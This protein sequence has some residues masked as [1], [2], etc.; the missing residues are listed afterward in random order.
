VARIL[1]LRLSAM[2]DVAMAV[3]VVAAL[4]RRYPDLKISLLT[5]PFFQ[6]FFREVPD[7]DFVPF[8]KKGRHR[9]L[10]GLFRLYREIRREHPAD[11]VAD[12]HNVLR[13]KLLRL[14]FRLSGRR[15]AVIDKGRREKQALTRQKN[16]I[17]RPL[18]PTI[19]RYA[20]VFA[21]LGYP[22]DLPEAAQRNPHPVPEA[23]A[24]LS[25][26]KT[27]TWIGI[28]PF[29]Q[30][31]GKR[32]PLE[33]MEQVIAELNG[34][35]NLTLFVFGGGPVEQAVA[36][37]WAEKYPHVISAIG[38]VKLAQELDLISNLDSMVSMD[39]SA[40]HMASLYGVPVISV[41]GAT[42][43]YAGF[44]GWGQSSANAVQSNLPCRPCSID[45]NK[46]C[47]YG[48]YR[49]L[50]Q[51]APEEIVD[52]LSRLETVLMYE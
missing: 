39:S 10:R 16:K 26:A 5:T 15:T 18:E 32:Y 12:L 9:G 49:C 23:I 36:D 20:D 14:L 52:V 50:S 51:I 33:F 40:M 48:D 29:A 43:P 11:A 17:L 19:H 21:R 2:G 1:I 45:G 47:L 42:H 22:V 31:L 8:D 41:W 28:A 13:T 35:N 34:R 3:P 7:L 30:H 38:K 37:E 24:A 4:R 27:G 44:M 25:G 6:P 46:P